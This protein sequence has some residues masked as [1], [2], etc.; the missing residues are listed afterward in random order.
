MRSGEKI[1]EK[2]LERRGR[3]EDIEREVEE[4]TSRKVATKGE[5]E[6]KS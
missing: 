6:R 1:R 3:N 5:A 4:R 2:E